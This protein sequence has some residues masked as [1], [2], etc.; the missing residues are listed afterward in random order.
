[1]S[2]QKAFDVVGFGE[3][4][5]DY[6]YRLPTLPVLHASAA[7][8][9][10]ASR[11]VLPG[12]QVATTLATCAALG[13]T[14]SDA[15]VF[16][17][18]ENGTHIRRELEARGVDTTQAIVHSAP[19]RYAVILVDESHGE[20]TVLWDRDERLNVDPGELRTDLIRAARVLHVDNVDEIASM[21]AVRIARDAGVRVTSDIDHV[22]DRTEQLL[23]LVTIPIFS[24]HAP[25]ELTGEADPERGLRTLRRRHDG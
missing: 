10:I 6:V 8:I 7:K 25:R 20:R 21:E 2:A 16:G 11:Q 5:I 17:D 4:S 1:M 14:T 3:N 18:D 15:G 24:E 13:L 23:S 9:R 19:N 12:G 22:T